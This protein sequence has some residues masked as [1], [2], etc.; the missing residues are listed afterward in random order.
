VVDDGGAR[1]GVDGSTNGEKQAVE[2][3]REEVDDG[4]DSSVSEGRG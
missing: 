2:W 3:R 4:D 1:E